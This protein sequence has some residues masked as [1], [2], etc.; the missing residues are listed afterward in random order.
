MKKSR[1]FLT[2]NT[3]FWSVLPSNLVILRK[4]TR[5]TTNSQENKYMQT[6]INIH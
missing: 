3:N 1:K 5:L 2:L 6:F 4:A